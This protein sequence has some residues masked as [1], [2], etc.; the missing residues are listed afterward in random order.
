MMIPPE[1]K[2]TPVYR[3][4]RWTRRRTLTRL[5]SLKLQRR[6]LRGRALV[7]EAALEACYVALLRDLRMAAPGEPLG[8]YLEFGVCHGASL[9]CM[10]RALASLAIPE[11][12][13]FG[14][15][16]FAGL[17]PEAETDEGSVWFP[18]Q[19]RSS[20][21]FTRRFLDRAGV[22]WGRVTLI[23]GWFQD[24][25]TEAAIARHAIRKASVIMVDCDIY[26]SARQALAFCEPLIRDRAA[27]LFDDW[28]SAG[29]LA[30]RG[31]GEK[32][33]F[34]EFLAEHPDIAAV[35]VESYTAN[36]AVFMVSRTARKQD[37]AR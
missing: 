4:L 15:D 12:R 9:A 11:V 10:H 37:A 1:L 16:S 27:I 6:A 17:P 28:R 7:P 24:T 3:A 26:S 34:D 33:A 21:A 8:D 23:K 20:L 18:G 35:E 25:L 32:R 2:R 19:Y 14:F 5:E 31:L 13:L 22:D 30:A 36:A 29:D